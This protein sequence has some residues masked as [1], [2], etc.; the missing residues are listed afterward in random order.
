MPPVLVENS[1]ARVTT[2]Y[3]VFEADQVL[4]HHQLN[5]VADYADDQIRLS[6][7]RLS[8]VGIAC[9]LQVSLGEAGVVLEGGLGVTTDGD[10]MYVHKGTFYDRWR[11]YDTSFPAYPPLY[12]GRNVNGAMYDAWELLPV[13]SEAG[14]GRPFGELV[15][16]AGRHP[17]TLAA[18]LLMESY[19]QDDDLC[20]GT[21]CDNLG[22]RAVNTLKLLLVE[23][24][25]LP[26]LRE[27]Q[28]TAADVYAELPEIAADRAVL[29]ASLSSAAQL[30]AAYRAACNAI[31]GRL[32]PV[33]PRVASRAGVVLGPVANAAS[34][35]VS[36]LT[37]YRT[38]FAGTRGGIQYYYDFLKD[39][40]DAYNELREALFG[41]DTW[42]AP[43]I[44]TFPKHLLLGELAP[45][46]D[47]AV[48]RTGWYPSPVTSPTSG[49][50]DHARFLVGRL[51]ALIRGFSVS[52]DPAL[53]LRVTPSMAEDRPLD[54]RAIPFYYTPGGTDPVRRHWS[55]RLVRR[56][57]ADTTYSYHASTYAAAG[58]PAAVPLG[59]QIGRSTF[60]RV[61]GV[62]GKPVETAMDL[63]EDAIADRNL[64]FSVRAVLLGAT[65]AGVVRRRPARV[66]DLHHL[67]Q[68]IRRDA[69][70]RLEDAR[71]FTA[72]Y[73]QQ[74]LTAVDAPDVFLLDEADARN[75][76]RSAAN[77]SGATVQDRTLQARLRMGGSY[78]SYRPGAAALQAD[79]SA[80]VEAATNLSFHATPVADTPYV[81]P[82]DSLAVGLQTQW[83]PWI[84]K[85]LDWKE[86]QEDTRLFFSAFARRHPQ[87]EHLGG[88]PRG[89]TLVLLHDDAGT[90]VGEVMLPYACCDEA[91]DETEPEL[92]E[93]REPPPVAME[94]PVRRVPSRKWSF[95]REW[96]IKEP[97][98]QVLRDA[99]VDLNDWMQSQSQV[100]QDQISWQTRYL[101]EERVSLQSDIIRNMDTAYQGVIDTSLKYRVGATTP[102]TG[103]PNFGGEYQYEDAR[104]GALAEA[105]R[106]QT[107]ALALL[108]Q[109]IGTAGVDDVTFSRLNSL[110][111]GLA[112]LVDSTAKY[113]AA[114]GIDIAVGTEGARAFEQV[115]FG[116]EA[117]RGTN[118]FTSVQQAL[119][120]VAARITN[121]RLKNEITRVITG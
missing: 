38:E 90:V 96:E 25:A 64:P 68:V 37:A 91:V 18:V 98:I 6:R 36:R 110:R 4:T 113:I 19:R 54:E 3:T 107:E 44:G 73:S 89:G 84:D 24:D 115:E 55:W 76:V 11:P 53:P 117:L 17:S 60:F 97:E 118:A 94:P 103:V 114:E 47:A 9:G 13:D 20:S 43:S 50:L 15:E 78:A 2:G 69:A 67:H 42:C 111:D 95:Q 108:E 28:T 70:L 121:T 85:V 34:T 31:H 87:V 61:E 93:H 80:A 101:Q 92:S 46:A 49:A 109:V 77:I 58:S 39:V 8:G 63:L 72:N 45:T 7:T 104:L 33:L 71:T 120:T 56:G 83:L 62:V 116:T 105:T 35:W 106:K 86:E 52:T 40:V 21:D 22:A 51:D 30:A 112:W 81:T 99:R 65:R 27:G 66:T 75:T 79:V 23:P 5:S 1:L 48:N 59:F 14:Q 100:L 16:A 12:A 88:V 119:K 41:D 74:V 82:L 26:A 57:A 29:P 102:Q 32:V 10:L